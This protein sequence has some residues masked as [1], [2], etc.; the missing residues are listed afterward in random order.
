MTY[1]L[2]GNEPQGK[3]PILLALDNSGSMAGP[4]EIWAK[5][6]AL[7]LLAIAGKQR[8]DLAVLPFGGAPSELRVFRFP[9]GQA[10][11]AD[12]LAC[13]SH[14]YGGGTEFVTWMRAALQLIDEAAFDRADVICVTDGL[15][16]LDPAAR[17]AWQ[18]RRRGRG[19]R[20]FGVLIGGDPAGAGLLAGISDA[21]LTLDL[22]DDGA[23]LS[24]IF[25][26]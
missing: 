9:R 1:E 25:A 12:T 5:A 4:N 3:G 11:P 10:S 20:C 13:A 23:V 2:V 7:A 24:T 17:A 19:M 15:V 8:R 14:F 26:I 18:E 6:V 21:V 16:A 22:A